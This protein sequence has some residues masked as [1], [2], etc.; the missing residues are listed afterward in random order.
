[1]IWFDQLCN[2]LLYR[3]EWMEQ[4][5]PNCP[6]IWFNQLCNMLLY[7]KERMEQQC[8]SCPMI[9]FNQLCNELEGLPANKAQSALLR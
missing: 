8:P 3:E 1:M 5:C 4:Q 2:I 6:M 7:R 9:W